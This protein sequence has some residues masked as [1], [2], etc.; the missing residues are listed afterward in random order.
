LLFLH[1]LDVGIDLN[2][3]GITTLALDLVYS[4][5]VNVGIDLNKEGITTILARY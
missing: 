4:K 2:K 3:E 5:S 1:Q